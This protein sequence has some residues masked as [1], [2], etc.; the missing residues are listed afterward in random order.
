M[1]L[2]YSLKFNM[3][4]RRVIWSTELVHP[5]YLEVDVH[6]LKRPNFLKWEYLINLVLPNLSSK[7][8]LTSAY[9]KLYQ[10]HIQLWTLK[11][12]YPPSK[13]I[14]SHVCGSNLSVYETRIW[15]IRS[16]NNQP[17]LHRNVDPMVEIILND[18]RAP[19]KHAYK[20]LVLA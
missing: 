14:Y 11:I 18:I 20:T 16:R 17:R 9:L 4:L 7:L 3:F 2:K 12:L 6:Y 13:T 1:F 5:R 15:L 8:I 19:D 10:T